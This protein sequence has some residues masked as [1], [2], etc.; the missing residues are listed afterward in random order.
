[1]YSM[2]TTN[3]LDLLAW[4][5]NVKAWHFREKSSY[6]YVS[7]SSACHIYCKSVSAC[8]SPSLAAWTEPCPSAA[9]AW[10]RVCW[11]NSPRTFTNCKRTPAP[12]WERGHRARREVCLSSMRTTA[13]RTTE[14]VPRLRLSELLLPPALSL[15][16][17]VD[18]WGSC[19][20]D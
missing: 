20:S 11:A 12:T 19:S 7:Y 15:L 2:K 9:P 13:A 17:T 18:A 14:A 10:A 1:M 3:H 16:Q 5:W 8:L 4:L 6:V